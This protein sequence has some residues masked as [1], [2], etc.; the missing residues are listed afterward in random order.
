MMEQ[1]KCTCV[2]LAQI[3]LS[4]EMAIVQGYGYEDNGEREADNGK[5]EADNGKRDT[6]NGERGHASR[7]SLC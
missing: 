4:I 5:R 6:D 1:L 7:V 2:G 3:L